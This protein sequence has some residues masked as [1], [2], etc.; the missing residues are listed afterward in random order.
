M[1]EVYRIEHT[2]TYDYDADVTDS[3]GLAY[4]R[5]ADLEHQVCLAHE[6]RI[7]PTASDTFPVEDVHGNAATYF[8][9]T[10]S[11]RRLAVRGV[12]V[13]EVRERAYEESVLATAWEQAV[14][15]VHPERLD[16]EATDFTLPSPLIGLEASAAVAAYAA[17]SF[18]PGRAIGEAVDELTH[19]IHTD[20]SYRTGVTGVGT[21]VTDVM[22]RRAGVCQ[23]FAQVLI[24]CL[25]SQ[26]LAGRYVSGYLAT[27]PPPGQRRL[28]GVDATHA[29][30]ECWLPDRTW[31]ALDP[32]N[33]LRCGAGH[34]TV[35][36]GR[37]YADVPP[38]RGV[39]F[40]D[41]QASQLHVSVDMRP[42]AD[43]APATEG[44]VPT[45]T[46]R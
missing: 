41:A 16:W 25:R 38:V 18:P 39:I 27:E 31:L 7:E 28:V 29:W 40:T 36:R 34:A 2:T 15:Q 13:V 20:F 32:T 43:Y 30:A 12:S 14:P 17:P 45:Q 5:P 42:L 8:H 4:L 37:D 21:S 19:R 46:R 44:Q 6:L 9:V 23:D 33:D 22:D 3:Y 10:I 26:G 24:A 35:A 11:H 1:S